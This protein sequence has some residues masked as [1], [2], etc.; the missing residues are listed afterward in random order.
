MGGWFRAAAV[1]A[2]VLAPL[3]AVSACASGSAPSA[4][5]GHSSRTGGSPATSSPAPSSPAAGHSASPSPSAVHPGS[6]PPVIP[7]G[8]APNIAVVRL[9]SRFTPGTLRL[10]TGQKFEVIVSRGVKPTGSGISGKCAPAAAARFSSAML[11]LSCT[12][13]SYL[14]TARQAG[15]TALEVTVRPACPPG[16]M[17]PQWVSAA[18]LTLTIS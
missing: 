15:R 14:Y 18:R 5:G 2:A 7:V 16:S 17:C 12:G 8:G 9:G 3:T 13:G 1:T 6:S 10:G 4:A 11:S